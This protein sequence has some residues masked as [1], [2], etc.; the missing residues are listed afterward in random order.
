MKAAGPHC[1]A[2]LNEWLFDTLVQSTG[3]PSSRPPLQLDPD[4]KNLAFGMVAL[5][6]AEEKQDMAAAVRRCAGELDGWAKERGAGPPA[7]DSPSAA[8]RQ[9]GVEGS[10]MM[11]GS[12]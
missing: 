10:G 3:P 8:V 9:W 4:C 7:S 2:C 6:T 12:P 5:L 11:G 1:R